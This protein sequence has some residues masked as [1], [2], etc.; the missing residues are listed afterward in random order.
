MQTLKTQNKTQG[1]TLFELMIAVTIIMVLGA[2]TV[3]Q[4]MSTI[5]DMSLRNAASDFSGLLQSARIQAVKKNTF[6]AVQSGSLGTNHPIYYVD[7]PT[8]SYVNGDAILPFDPNVT[9][10]Q[11]IG[12]GAPNEGT[13]IS[14]LNF[15]VYSGG[16]PPSFNARGLP[17]L[18]TL[19]TCVQTTGQG[20]VVFMSKNAA[21][22]NTPWAAVVINP[23]GRVQLWTSGTNGS[24]IQRN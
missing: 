22:G 16:N 13:F 8:A 15:T 11:G 20:F 3:P 12:S 1:F 17:C 5:S 18:G 9:L 10:H 21:V 23:S 14:G 24:W 2:L 4:M 7:K 6:Y 19:T